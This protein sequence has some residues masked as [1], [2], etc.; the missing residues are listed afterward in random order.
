MNKT[1]SK[2]FEAG[3]W[4]SFE[5]R[6]WSPRTRA[7]GSLFPSIQVGQSFSLLRVINTAA[8]L[9]ILFVLIESLSLVFL[10]YSQSQFFRSVIGTRRQAG[11][12]APSI[13]QPKICAP[14]VCFHFVHSERA[15]H[16]Q[17]LG[18]G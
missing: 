6:S 2:S 8:N 14:M 12:D 1:I 15:R 16:Y 11:H 5:V 4:S 13:E 3:R 9:S 7:N 10:L 18:T 17:A